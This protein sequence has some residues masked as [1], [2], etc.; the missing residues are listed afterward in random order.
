MIAGKRRFTTKRSFF[1]L[2]VLM[3]MLQHVEKWAV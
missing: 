3:Q 2:A 1:L